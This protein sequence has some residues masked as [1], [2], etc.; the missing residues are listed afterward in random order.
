MTSRVYWLEE[1]HGLK[2]RE[3]PLSSAPLG[4]GEYTARTRYSAVSTGTE[5]AAWSGKP[6]LRPS[7]VYPRLMGYCNLAQVCET[8]PDTQFEKG[9]WVL[10]HQS[11]RSFYRAHQSGVLFHLSDASQTELQNVTATYLYHLGYSALLAADFRLGHQVAIVGLGLLGTT[12]AELVALSGLAPWVFSDHAAS[13][14]GDVFP[15]SA[16]TG[17]WSAADAV[18]TV[19]NTS[20]A[21]PDFQL[22]LRLARKGGT[23]VCLGF[24]GRGESAPDFNPLDSRYFYD[25]QLTIK[26]CGY[27][28]ESDL[29]PIDQRFTLKRNMAYL[30]KLVLAGKL[31]AGALLKDQRRWDAL[32]EAYADLEKRRAG[33]FSVLIDW[34]GA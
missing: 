23:I 28:T 9:A 21:W 15:K 25:K 6:P 20:N 30:A 32:P 19:I 27:V 31:G 14:V 12:T 26:H 1:P 34:E 10:T 8:G 33:S 22:S 29:T 18:D 2:L 16:E 3:E 11:H 5:I 13:G 24:P 7:K 4:P 17:P